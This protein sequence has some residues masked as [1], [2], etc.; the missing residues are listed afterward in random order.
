[1]PNE[2]NNSESEAPKVAPPQD[3]PA[4]AGTKSPGTLLA[5]PDTK[6]R[7]KVLKRNAVQESTRDGHEREQ[8]LPGR[9]RGGNRDSRKARRP[10]ASGGL[11][12]SS[13]NN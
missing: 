3:P 10:T 9:G 7:P 11:Q 13:Q 12:R 2:Y 1:V 4:R 8:E 5:R 6:L